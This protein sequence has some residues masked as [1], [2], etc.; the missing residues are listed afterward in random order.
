LRAL[1]GLQ[2][3]INGQDLA[4]DDRSAVGVEFQ[5]ARMGPDE[6]ADL[7]QASAGDLCGQ[8][9]DVAH[10]IAQRRQLNIRQAA[11]RPENLSGRAAGREASQ[12]RKERNASAG[13]QA[14]HAG[15]MTFPL[16]KLLSHSG[17]KRARAAVSSA[18]TMDANLG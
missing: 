4:P 3:R 8:P 2:R 18:R 15:A 1:Q 9:A 5:F 11:D 7:I 14:G 12:G 13:A 16:I 6:G 17:M 10:G